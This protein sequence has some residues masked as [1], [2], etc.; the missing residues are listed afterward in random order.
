MSHFGE[1]SSAL[2][3]FF[4]LSLNVSVLAKNKYEGAKL[5]KVKAKTVTKCS[6]NC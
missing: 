3:F 5:I 6:F 1:S 4:F 2:T